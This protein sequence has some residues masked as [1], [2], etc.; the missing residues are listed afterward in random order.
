MNRLGISVALVLSTLLLLGGCATRPI[1]GP[2]TKLSLNKGYQYQARQRHSR[3][4][5]NLVILAF[6]GGGTRAAAFSYGVLE[7]LRR[8]VVVGPIG[9]VR[10]IDEVDVITGVS[11]GSF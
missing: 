7:T 9:T 5:D 11:G 2:I 3:D 8:T 1:N 10:L 4:H 6:S